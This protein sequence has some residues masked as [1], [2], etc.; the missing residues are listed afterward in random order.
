MHK[1]PVIKKII[2][3]TA[4]ITGECIAIAAVAFIAVNLVFA[5]TRS[6]L[7]YSGE[8]KIW[9][10]RGY[11]KQDIP[12]SIESYT[13]AFSLGARGIELDIHYDIGREAYIVSHD[14]PYTPVNGRVL[15]LEAV[16]SRVGPLG[17]FWLDFKNLETLSKENARVA[18]SRLYSLLAT[19]RVTG[20]VIIESK[21][22]VNLAVASRAGLYTSYWIEP[23][24][25]GFFQFWLYIYL[26]KI[27]YIYGNFSAISMDYNYYSH[28]IEEIFAHAPIHL[29]TVNDVTLL[30]RLI[31][32]P[33]VKIIL[34]DENRYLMKQTYDSA[35]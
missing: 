18:I 28:K 15:T 6:P 19:Y 20:K 11:W 1:H 32:K 16:L 30:N 4:T 31:D 26:C 29:F 35:K 3:T 21:N 5:Y 10:H 22:P 33:E 12:N 25:E 13:K 34:S 7:F 9:A 23:E 14:Y 8:Y 17:R 27:F 24:E 2:K